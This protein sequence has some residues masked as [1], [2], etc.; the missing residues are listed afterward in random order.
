MFLWEIINHFVFMCFISNKKCENIFKALFC[1]EIHNI[2]Q[3]QLI[4]YSLNVKVVEISPENYM[5][6]TH[7]INI[8]FISWRYKIFYQIFQL[9]KK[10][11]SLKVFSMF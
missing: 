8:F 1:V 6:L 4:S 10:D 5:Q 7:Y 11:L 3:I 2:N 9:D